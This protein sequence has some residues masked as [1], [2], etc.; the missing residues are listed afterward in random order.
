[1]P[2]CQAQRKKKT[3]AS[4]APAADSQYCLNKNAMNNIAVARPA[5]NGSH[6]EP[7]RITTDAGRPL[8]TSTLSVWRWPAAAVASQCRPRTCSTPRSGLSQSGYRPP[9]S[10]T[11]A[12]LYDGDRKSTRLNSSHVAISYAVFCLKKKN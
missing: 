5:Y 3:S 4:D 11:L 12:K 8:T 2:P 9:T 1:M 6:V 10:G 7:G